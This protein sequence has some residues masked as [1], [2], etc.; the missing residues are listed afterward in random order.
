MMGAEAIKIESRKRLDHARV[1][2][3]TTGEKFAEPDKSWVFNNINLNKLGVTLNL[4]QPKAVELA[5]RIIEVSDVVAQ[6]MRPGVM[7]RL[8]LGYEALREIKPSIIYLS[9]SAEGATG[10]QRSYTGYAS[11]FAAIGGLSGITGYPDGWPG[12]FRGEID[13]ISATTSCFAILAALNH[14][15]RTGQGQHIDLSSSEAVSVL[16]GDVLLDYTM[17]NRVQHRQGNRDS[18]MAPH[19]CYRCQGEDKWISIAIA[20]DQEWQALCDAM[21][22]PD[23]AKDRRFSGGLG[24]H[25]HQAELDE[26]IETWT[27]NHTHREAMEILQKAGVAGVPSF[28]SADLINDPHL[29]E[30]GFWLDV[31]H[32][33]IG[34]TTVSAPPWRLS[35]TPIEVRRRAPLIGEHNHYVFG[36]LLG[37][38]SVE[39]ARLEEENVIY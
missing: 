29:R 5:K 10:P 23:W 19:N 21:G 24:R 27:M 39:I 15:Q 34:N 17:N 38:S 31:E 9:S 7:D 25:Q 18:F 26:L 20:N 28:S 12:D 30:R 11:N 22:N 14:R 1:T 2:A 35:E 13:I 36:E 33:V 3:I 6:N 37:L 4:S 32:P 16:I 8:G